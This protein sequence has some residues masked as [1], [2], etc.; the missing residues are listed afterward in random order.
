MNYTANDIAEFFNK[1]EQSV[2][3]VIVAQTKFRPYRKSAR[4]IDAMAVEAKKDLR[5]A[6]NCFGKQ[7]YPNQTNLVIRKPHQYRPLALVSIE[8]IQETTD[9]QQTIHFN[10]SLGN[11]PKHLCTTMIDIHFRHAWHVK[12]NQPND[13]YTIATA[14]YHPQKTKGNMEMLWFPNKSLNLNTIINPKKE[15]GK[16]K[17]RSHTATS[18]NTTF[19][20][21]AMSQAKVLK[22]G[23]HKSAPQPP[24]TL[25]D[26]ETNKPCHH[27]I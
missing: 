27:R 26:Y 5:H 6:L 15:V 17:Q 4:A 13:I 10:I 18:E 20:A 1:H 16:K 3:H 25:S 23:L 24:R 9:E 22:E 7:I 21:D 14:D 12:A 2:T 8:N 19:G 11:L